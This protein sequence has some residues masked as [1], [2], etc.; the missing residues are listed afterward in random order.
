MKLFRSFLIPAGLAATL[1]LPIAVAA[2][3]APVSAT[4]P[5][6]GAKHHNGFM[7][8]MRGLNLSAD[9]QARIKAFATQ[10]HQA[11][12]KGST[13]DPQARDAFHASI[14]NVL[15]AQQ[16]TQFKA[17]Q[18]AG[19]QR[20]AENEGRGAGIM[21]R[22]TELNLTDAQKSQI[23]ALMTQFRQAHPQGSAPDPQ[24]RQALHTQITN[25][26]T[27]QQ[28]TQLQQ[29]HGGAQDKPPR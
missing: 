11:H 15:T 20:G 23:Q 26:L 21:R 8:A 4:A 6:P 7:R 14:M 12:P 29:M 25:I 2:Q 17:N 13:P 24:A 22:F 9:Q 3:T 18:Q 10:Y 1:A 16:Q 28:R 5:A 19:E 27:P